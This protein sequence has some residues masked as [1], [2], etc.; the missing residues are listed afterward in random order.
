M[1]QL[2][3]MKNQ[4]NTIREVMDILR[5][6]IFVCDNKQSYVFDD[7]AYAIL[8]GDFRL[9]IRRNNIV[10][11]NINTKYKYTIFQYES[12]FIFRTYENE[13]C[14]NENEFIISLEY[15]AN[16]TYT[17]ALISLGDKTEVLRL[18]SD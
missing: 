2:K 15:H 10:W 7:D 13:L 1:Y 6:K 11:E 18:I 3:K 8:Q 9:L 5:S 4:F 17:V 14:E 16:G 12:N